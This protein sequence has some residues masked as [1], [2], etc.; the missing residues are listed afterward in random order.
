MSPSLVN[1]TYAS[2]GGFVAVA[3]IIA[4]RLSKRVGRLEVIIPSLLIGVVCTSLLGALKPFYTEPRVMIPLFIARSVFMGSTQALQFS[5]TADYTP[6][7][8][9][10]RFMALS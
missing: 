7:N 9:R 5:I 2:M 8:M 4:Q 10:A 3:T 1:L 6:K